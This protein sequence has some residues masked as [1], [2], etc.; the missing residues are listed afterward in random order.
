MTG[1]TLDEVRAA[2]QPPTVLAR[3]NDEH[4]AGR[5]YMRKVSPAATWVFARLGWSPN[6]VTVA[7]IICGI[8]A[9]VVTAV[10]GLASAVGAAV[11]VQFYLLLD[12]ADGE[13]ARWSGR[14]S[15]AGIFL[16]RM[17]HYFC[18]A[19]LLV[20]LG[21]R[22]EGSFSLSSRWIT[23]GLAAALL[24]TLLKAESDGV[25]VARAK[26]GLEASHGDGALD[27]RGRGLASARRLASVLRLHRI[28]QAVELS[29]LILAAAIAD[30]ARGGLLATRVLLLACLVVSG[31]MVIAHLVAIVASRRLS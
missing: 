17:G 2:G 22:A 8:A 7:F 13:L 14:F 4:W 15:A 9:G 12:C 28:T 1:P 30:A 18:E 26:S 16:D 3:L 24:A 11:L 20:G 25:I 10:G 31:L 23:S 29:L 19:A 5:L 21:F 27:P 6:A